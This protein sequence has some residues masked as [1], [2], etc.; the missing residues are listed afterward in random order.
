LEKEDPL[1]DKLEER[2]FLQEA[3]ELTELV[4]GDLWYT[5]AWTLQESVQSP[6][7]VQLLFRCA[8]SLSRPKWM[9]KLSRQIIFSESVIHTGLNHVI[10]STIQNRASREEEYLEL[11][12]RA[13]K[14]K[15]IISDIIPN[16]KMLPDRDNRDLS[17]HRLGAIDALRILGPR[18]LLKISDLIAILGNL[19]QY[20]LRLDTRRLQEIGVSFANSAFALALLNGDMSLILAFEAF[21]RWSTVA[22]PDS[23]PLKLLPVSTFEDIAKSSFVTSHDSTKLIGRIRPPIFHPLGM[24]LCGWLW[25][26]EFEL[27]Y[28]A[29]RAEFE[30][31]WAGKGTYDLMKEIFWRLLEEIRIDGLPLLSQAL[32]RTSGFVSIPDHTG[33][34]LKAALT[35][36]LPFEIDGVRWGY[37]A[38]GAWWLVS[39]IMETGRIYFGQMAENSCS[40]SKEKPTFIL[41][42]ESPGLVQLFTPA[43]VL[44][45]AESSMPPDD[46]DFLLAWWANSVE[47]ESSGEISHHIDD[48]LR[49]VSKIDLVTDLFQI[50]CRYLPREEFYVCGFREH[51]VRCK[52]LAHMVKWA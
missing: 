43:R 13:E 35:P 2:S 15:R 47:P 23:A 41:L 8:D 27:S 28:H 21:A 10:F 4:A 11:N 17:L 5:R 33:Q 24:S 51:F 20:K 45:H 36:C 39:R 7:P 18:K 16:Y 1:Y 25:A 29:L 9:G 44:L 31:R 6:G 3:V 49:I 48:E 50:T 42:Q 19:C 52:G 38:S 46:P 14:A 32:F 37:D 22:A 30:E 40:C 34:E 12:A 26:F